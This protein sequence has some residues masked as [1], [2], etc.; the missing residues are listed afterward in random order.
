MTYDMQYN[1]NSQIKTINDVEA[2]FQHLVSERSLS[3]HPDD[4]FEDYISCDDGSNIFSE[5]ECAI[6]NRLMDECFEVCEKNGADIYAIG[7]AFMR[8]AL[9]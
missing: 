4:R 6:Y 3:F 9:A 2:F 7:L 5:K 1:I 8:K